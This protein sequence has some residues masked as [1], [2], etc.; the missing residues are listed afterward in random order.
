VASLAFIHGLAFKRAHDRLFDFAKQAESAGLLPRAA[1]AAA[2]K[3]TS[4]AERAANEI[5][6]PLMCHL[7]GADGQLAQEEHEFFNVAVG[8]KDAEDLTLA[9]VTKYTDATQAFRTSVPELVTAL[10]E[11]DKRSAGRFSKPRTRLS[12]DALRMVVA[13]CRLVG[14]VDKSTS[15]GEMRVANS[16]VHTIGTYLFNAGVVEREAL[17]TAVDDALL[18]ELLREGRAAAGSL[19]CAAPSPRRIPQSPQARASAG[20]ATAS[21]TAK[22]P[23]L[24]AELDALVGL[25][26]VKLDVRSLIN[27]IRVRQMRKERGLQVPPLS[28][29]MAFT[30]NPGTGKTTVARILAEIY[31]E[32]GLLRRGHLVETDRAGLVAGYVGQT[33][34]K[35]KS[36]VESALGGVLFIDEAYSLAAGR[37]E[38]DFGREAI[39]TLLKL[40]EDERD[41]LIVIV[42]GY[43]DKMNEFFESNPGLRSRFNKFIRFPDYDAEELAEIFRRM[44][45]KQDYRLTPAADA[46]MQ[47]ILASCYERRGRNFGNARLVRNFFEQAIARHSDR[48][49][50][51]ANP[52]HDDL[53]TIS[54]DDLPRRAVLV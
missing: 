39:E 2:L 24:L 44:A 9:D 21:Q 27:H 52:S 28:L 48:I 6:F 25:D 54:A 13:M 12:L 4:A 5:S 47:A 8:T 29:H 49:V 36:V 20:D 17:A 37:G 10:A 34:L 43:D 31:R 18:E 41:D 1:A 23:A 35:V 26:E 51:L 16:Y 50:G 46:D 38:N 3:G 53:C 32:M 15:A 30:G 11:L 42:A 45:A 40:M 19:D 22:L 7:I 14:G 33:A